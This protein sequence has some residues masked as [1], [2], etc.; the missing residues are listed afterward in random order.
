MDTP[1]LKL[2]PLKDRYVRR[3][4]SVNQGHS[5]DSFFADF[6]TSHGGK[7]VE[8]GILLHEILKFEEMD[9]KSINSQS[10]TFIKLQ[11]SIRTL[12]KTLVYK[13]R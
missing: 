13:A 4:S 12:T 3:P 11:F 8:G 5:V 7:K 6:G 2:K 9:S 10:T 1:N